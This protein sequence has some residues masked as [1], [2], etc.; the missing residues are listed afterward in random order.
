[1]HIGSRRHRH[2]NAEILWHAWIAHQAEHKIEGCGI[3]A[4][5]S[6]QKHRVFQS[7]LFIWRPALAS[8]TPLTRSRT[9]GIAVFATLL[10]FEIGPI[11]E[12]LIAQLAGSC[13]SYFPRYSE[14]IANWLVIFATW[15]AELSRPATAI[16]RCSDASAERRDAFRANANVGLVTHSA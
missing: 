15:S 9:S 3:R 5:R 4:R 14:L 7:R 1:M 8:A 12:S 11:Y 6:R 16:S 13:T 10:F 2:L